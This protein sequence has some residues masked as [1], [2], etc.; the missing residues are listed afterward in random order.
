MG[1]ARHR[2]RM[3]AASDIFLGWSEGIEPDRYYYWRQLR[4]MKTSVAVDSMVP[5]G[6]EYYIRICGSSLTRA[7]ARSGDPMAI[8][9]H[10]G[11]EKRFEK[12]IAEFAERYADQNNEDDQ[13]LVEAIDSAHRD[14]PWSLNSTRTGP[15]ER[16]I[17]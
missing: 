17:P 15:D 12:A 3:Q 1:A 6:R 4:H 16:S 8:A 10:L 13:A 2:Q 14:Q 9:A 7:H 11:T 5:T